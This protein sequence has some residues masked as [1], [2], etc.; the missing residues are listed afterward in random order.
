MKNTEM[1]FAHCVT[2]S[3]TLP[4]KDF[5]DA[6]GCMQQICTRFDVAMESI[7][8]EVDPWSRRMVVSR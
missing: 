8:L 3:D 1:H 7:P 6:R 5:A 2:V 4:T